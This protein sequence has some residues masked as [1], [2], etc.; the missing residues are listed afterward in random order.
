MTTESGI[1]MISPLFF[2]GVVENNVDPRLEGRV[3]VRAFNIHGTIDE[4]PTEFLPWAICLVGTF[5]NQMVVPPINSWV[6]G[7][8]IDGRAAQ[9]PML[10]GLVP[11]QMTEFNN[12]G[13]QGWG[14]IPP[15]GVLSTQGSR[16]EDIG[17]PTMPRSA[18]GEDLSSTYLI[19]MEA[20]RVTDVPTPE[21]LQN[22][23]WSEPSPAYDAKYPFNR[24][25]ETSSGHVVEYDDTPGAERILTYHRSGAYMQMDSRGSMTIKAMGDKY[26]ISENNTH[27]YSGGQANIVIRGDAA[28]YVGGSMTHE[29][30]GDY[31]L[32]VHGDMTT[33]VG[34]KK[35][36]VAGDSIIAKSS[37]IFAEATAE[38]IT[39]KAAHSIQMETVEAATI[40]GKTVSVQAAERMDMKGDDVRIQGTGATSISSGGSMMVDPAGQLFLRSGNSQAPGDVAGVES[41]E[42]PVPTSKSNES[43]YEGNPYNGGS[44]DSLNR[45]LPDDID[46]DAY[47]D[48]GT[49]V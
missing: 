5:D 20:N 48:S 16:P 18:R 21:G 15:D 13:A 28:V 32:N 49:M 14:V 30:M 9:Q 24:V 44:L 8:F 2:V 19:S 45:T 22:V 23:S 33:N 25:L 42:T 10:I 26:D 46:A 37:L 39:L 43:A 6:F 40:K 7:F 17:Q 41:I 38:S 11:T 34:G 31:N 1:G 29:V 4:I 36:V 3:Q 35:T 27:I 12:P 47:G